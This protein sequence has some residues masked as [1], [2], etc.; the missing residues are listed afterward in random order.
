MQF[1]IN[2]RKD[3]LEVVKTSI[4]AGDKKIYFKNDAGDTLSEISFDD[5]NVITG[6]GEKAVLRL[7]FVDG[8]NILRGSASVAGEVSNF[9]IQT[10]GPLT[11]VSGSVGFLGSLADIKFNKVAWSVGTSITLTNFDIVIPS[12]A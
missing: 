8:T 6:V 2:L 1:E 10:T 7:E 11:V 5:A 9:E 12:G 4:L 3:M